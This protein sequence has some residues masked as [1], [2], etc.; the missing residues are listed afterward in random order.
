MTELAQQIVHYWLAGGPL[1]LPLAGVSV[2]I[3]A[4]FIRSRT[5]LLH[6]DRL[7]RAADEEV[8]CAEGWQ[9]GFRRDFLVLTALTASAPL[10]GLLG[11][12]TGM[13]TTFQAVSQMG[14]DTGTRVAGGISRALITTQFGLV[15][16]LPGVFGLAHLRRLMRQVDTHM[17]QCRMALIAARPDP[18][19]R[20]I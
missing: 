5:S 6:L 2:L 10:L 4:W 15:I 7:A 17:I 16:A 19:G 12:V 11:T 18:G 1:L 20:A 14:G 13:I 8:C 3:W 9:Q